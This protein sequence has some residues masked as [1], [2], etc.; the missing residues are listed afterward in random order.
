MV[1]V[2]FVDVEL[3]LP[4]SVGQLDETQPAESCMRA[5]VHRIWKTLF[6][7]VLRAKNG[8]TVQQGAGELFARPV[9]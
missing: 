8:P 4:D 9:V 1:L 6:H 5:G 2:P 3:S 7:R